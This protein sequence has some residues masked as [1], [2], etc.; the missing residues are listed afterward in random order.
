MPTGTRTAPTGPARR[1]AVL[2]TLL[3]GALALG[4]C[5]VA[6]HTAALAV[7]RAAGQVVSEYSELIAA[8]AKTTA[9]QAELENVPP[10]RFEELNAL[11]VEARLG[12]A[13]ELEERV[14]DLVRLTTP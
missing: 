10:E 9:M 12:M 7:D 5:C 3:A 6:H 13:K 2:A 1:A 8:G 4:G 14:D 11:Q